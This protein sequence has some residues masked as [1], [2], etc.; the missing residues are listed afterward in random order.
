M[1]AVDL[2]HDADEKGAIENIVCPGREKP[3]V[4]VKSIV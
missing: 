3:K 2:Y 4:A 1:H